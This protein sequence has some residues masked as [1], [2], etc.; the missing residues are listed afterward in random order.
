MSNA[1]VGCSS[2]FTSPKSRRAGNGRGNGFRHRPQRPTVRAPR[3]RVR[4]L[5]II[6]LRFDNPLPG[7]RA[8]VTGARVSKRYGTSRYE[9]FSRAGTRW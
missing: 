4:S 5:W 1:R 3:G 9:R 2:Q 8:I 6:F 7:R